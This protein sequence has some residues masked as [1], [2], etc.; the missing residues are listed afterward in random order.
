[1]TDEIDTGFDAVIAGGPVWE[2]V[3][4]SSPALHPVVEANPDV[5][6]AVTPLPQPD[7][8]PEISAPG[9]TPDG[10]QAMKSMLAMPA[11]TYADLAKLAREIAMDIKERHVAL[12]DFNLTD[13]QYDFL[14]SHND[15][16][17]QALKAACIEWHS[18]LSTQ[19]RIKLEAAAILEDGLPGLGARM[20]NKS[21]QLSGVVEVAKLFAKVAG[22]G[23]REAGMATPGERFT[24][25]IDLGGDQKIAVSTGP[26]PQALAQPALSSAQSSVLVPANGGGKV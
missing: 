6:V 18:P 3:H 21:E 4:T 22:V 26:A 2:D 14:E 15:F 11:L 7:P 20:Q 5:T 8:E 9:L 25:N 16:Y 17:K 1:M 24:I 12:K 13:A 19:E 10:I 23:E